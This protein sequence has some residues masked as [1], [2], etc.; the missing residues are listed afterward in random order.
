MVAGGDVEPVV[1]GGGSRVAA[2]VAGGVQEAEESGW[3]PALEPELEVAAAAAEPVGSAEQFDSLEALEAEEKAE[4]GQA[5]LAMSMEKG[6]EAGDFLAK[7]M[8]KKKPAAPEP[9]AEPEITT[10]VDAI[11]AVQVLNPRSSTRVE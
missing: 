8:A 10:L 5:A 6:S 4:A 3:R 11:R 1:A 2:V 7:I 9:A